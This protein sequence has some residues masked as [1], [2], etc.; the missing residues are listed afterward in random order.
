METSKRDNQGNEKAD[1]RP[2]VGIA[3]VSLLVCGLFF[4]LLI[5]GLAQTIF[6]TQ[7][8]GEL[9][10][11]NGRTIGSNLIA[12][13]FTLPIF[14]HP[15]NNSASGLDPD[16]TVQDAFSQIPRISNATGIPSASLQQLVDQKIDP[17][18]RFVE[19]QYVNVLS[20]NIQLVESYPSTYSA[21]YW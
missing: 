15:R 2:V 3:I 4:P 7:A 19:L 14:F 11:F 18:G 12:Q 9:V 13:N 8:N 16:I 5:T 10:P 6:P 20:L 17:L 21:Y 1:Y